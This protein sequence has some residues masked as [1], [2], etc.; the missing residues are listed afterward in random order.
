MDMRRDARFSV[1]T[2]HDVDVDADADVGCHF[3]VSPLSSLTIALVR[4]H[5]AMETD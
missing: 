4:W 5:N 2:A 1:S 3:G